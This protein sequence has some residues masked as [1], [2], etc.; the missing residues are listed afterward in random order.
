[1]SSVVL[2]KRWHQT[3]TWLRVLW[4]FSRPH[5]IIGTSLSVTGLAMVA[6]ASTTVGTPFSWLRFGGAISAALVPS[7]CANLYIVGLNQLEDVDIDRINKPNLPLASGEFSRKEGLLI[8]W[9]TG[10]LALILSAL[11]GT[12]LWATVILSVA[13]GTVYSLP[14]FRLKRFPFWAALCIFGVRGIIVNL[15]F[16]LHFQQVLGGT[17]R[18]SAEVW[19]LTGFVILFAFAIAI[20]K[21]MPDAEGDR[22]FKISTLTI[23]LGTQSVFKISRWVLTAC[24]GLMIGATALGLIAVQPIF[25]IATQLGLMGWLWV[26]STKVN[27]KEKRQ[28]SQFYQFI[29]KLFFL[30]YILFPLACLWKS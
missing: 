9:I 14:P 4:K 2:S 22:Q 19:A 27:L 8:V 16:F 28:I 29:W 21:D 17:Q 26:N 18:L 11:Q 12:A 1:M 13:I 5:T 6:L 25:L 7:L 10:A 30:E 20:F 24:Y 3:I 23:R 15:G